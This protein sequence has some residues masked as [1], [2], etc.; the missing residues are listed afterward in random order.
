[1]GEKRPE[2]FVPDTNGYIVP[3]VPAGFGATS[4]S[5]GPG[6]SG[7]HI[8]HVEVHNDT[9]A[10]AFFRIANFHMAGR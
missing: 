8:D 9:D 7:I 4:T 10:D 6:A 1:M 5:A 2:L 3:S